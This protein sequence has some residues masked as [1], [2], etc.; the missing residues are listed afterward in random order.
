MSRTCDIAIHA[1]ENA[2]LFA[3]RSGVRT[4]ASMMVTTHAP[5]ARC[6]RMIYACGIDLVQYIH[7][8]SNDNGLNL[9]AHRGITTRQLKGLKLP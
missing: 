4:Y 7:P 6:A 2:I 3:A 8:P 9:L 5:C 1:E